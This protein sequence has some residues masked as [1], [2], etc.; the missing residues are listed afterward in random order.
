MAKESTSTTEPAG[1]ATTFTC[2]SDTAQ[3]IFLA[4]SFNDWDAT[5]TPMTRDNEGNW[6]VSLPLAPGRY[7]YKFVVDDEWCCV[8]GSTS[9][10]V[11]S[12]DCVM[13]EYGTMNRVIEVE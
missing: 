10:D 4:G 6:T 7:E 2:H 3:A 1:T 8:P 9:Q 11:Q 13:N 12:P 5:A